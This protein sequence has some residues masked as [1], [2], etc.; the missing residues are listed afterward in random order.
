MKVPKVF[1]VVL[2]LFV[3]GVSSDSI[4]EETAITERELT[5]RIEKLVVT[6]NIE[7]AQKI[8]GVA[9]YVDTRTKKDENIL[10]YSNV[11]IENS[12]KVRIE[13]EDMG[14]LVLWEIP[15]ED[16]ASFKTV[17]VNVKNGTLQLVYIWFFFP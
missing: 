3:A 16:K 6:G 14:M 9:P 7:K 10:T 11:V 13:R 4:S 8:V 5:S 12:K 2:A 15:S 1:L 17:G